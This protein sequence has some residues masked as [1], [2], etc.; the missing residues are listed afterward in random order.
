[1][2]SPPGTVNCVER[3]LVAG[4]ADASPATVRMIQN[5]TTNRLWER[6]QRVSVAIATSRWMD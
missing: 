4:R 3:A 5:A 6:T 2:P 1:M